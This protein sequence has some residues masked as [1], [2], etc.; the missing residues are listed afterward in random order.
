MAELVFSKKQLNPLIKKFELDVESNTF[1]NIIGMFNGSTDYQIWAIKLVY[2][3]VAP[4]EV[5]ASIKSWADN[6][7][8]EIKNLSKGNIIL[9]KTANDL[10]LLNAEM[11][12]IDKLSFI[13]N[14]IN[15][16]NTAQRELLRQNILNGITSISKAIN[17]EKIDYW[18]A[19]FTK[20]G[21]LENHRK[22][23][24]ISTASALY[25]FDNLSKHV[26]SALAS[27][28]AWDK[29]DMLAYAKINANDCSVVYNEGPIVV[30]QIPS[31][32][33]SKL[34]CGNGR[35][36]WCLTREERY[37][38]QYVKETSGTK[39][40]FLFDFSKP[41][42]DE[43]AHIGFTVRAKSG[44]V[45]AH[46][47]KNSN[48]LG[49]GISYKNKQV[50]IH[51]ALTMA[52]VPQHV[53]MS[54]DKPCYTWSPSSL[55]SLINANSKDI[56]LCYANNNQYVVMPLSRKGLNILAKHTYVGVDNIS[57]DDTRYKVYV[58]LDFNQAYNMENSI[59][60][61]YYGKDKYGT[62]SLNRGYNAYNGNVT[63]ENLPI[64]EKLFISREALKPEI[65]IHKLID[66]GDEAAAIE[67]IDNNPN[68][69]VNFEFSSN[70]PVFYAIEK[71]M[72][73]LFSKIISSKKFN[74]ASY[75]GFSESVLQSLMFS[76]VISPSNVI[77][78]KH[79]EN[80]THMINEILES[81]IF[82][83][84]TQDINLDTALHTAC[85]NKALIWIV[86]KLVANPNVDINLINDFNM[87]PLTTAIRR[88]NLE[89]IGL[90]SRRPDLVIRQEDVEL[91]KTKKIDLGEFFN[92]KSIDVKPKT[93][94]NNELY[95]IFMRAFGEC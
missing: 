53:F 17:N 42:N 54:I 18:F 61:L 58:V 9:Y 34:L 24:L 36:G 33:S 81:P 16:F 68:M 57:F 6:N 25:D 21:R 56:A 64:N 7:P 92:L 84:N 88:C 47:T 80:I 44:I 86:D 46:S 85:D 30:M 12:A 72:F 76:Y 69:D 4:L 38:N 79:N 71:Q 67:L 60:V 40:Y 43:L 29:E 93:E 26:I 28:Y 23:K 59:L 45:N 41:E 5:I 8:T 75:D 2:G 37:F 20:M 90:L 35:T 3:G 89:A 48:M 51:D 55:E 19:V 82:D 27:T 39:Q 22:E 78:K 94:T 70:L 32:K 73:G 31:F 65:M 13:K 62:F 10:A 66:E 91:A 83:F 49:S 52:H 77:E 87:S 50:S 1:K 63:R 95:D 15:R 11:N 14:N 74:P